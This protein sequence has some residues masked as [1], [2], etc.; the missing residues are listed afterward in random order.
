MRNVYFRVFFVHLTLKVVEI[1]FLYSGK[2]LLVFLAL[3]P[4]TPT[5]RS[6]SVQH[7]Y[8]SALKIAN[9]LIKGRITIKR[10]V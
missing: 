10:I 3:D 9:Y 8:I 7:T 6:S 5:N 2:V 1:V 4:Q